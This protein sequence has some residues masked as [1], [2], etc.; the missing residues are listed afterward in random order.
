V[1]GASKLAT[2]DALTGRDSSVAGVANQTN[3]NHTPASADACFRP[4]LQ[5]PTPDD[6]LRP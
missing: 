6:F 1:P 5:F 2:H 4:R 3:T